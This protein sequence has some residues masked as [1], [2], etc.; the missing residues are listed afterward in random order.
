MRDF[1]FI[2]FFLGHDAGDLCRSLLSEYRLLEV[3]RASKL[4][5]VWQHGS[6][7]GCMLRLPAGDSRLISLIQSLEEHGVSVFRRHDREFS[8]KE[9][10]AAPW[11]ILRVATAGLLGG[12]DYDQPYDHSRACPICGAGAQ[13][14]PPL[15]AQI[16]KVGKK[17]ID[18]LVYENHLIASRPVV[19]SLLALALTGLV[20]EP[21][22]SPRKHPSQTHSWIRIHA[23][24]SLLDASSLG[25]RRE[26]PC[27]AC[28]RSGHYWSSDSPWVPSLRREPA[29]DFSLSWQYF[30]DW[31]Q[32]RS[33]NQVRAVGGAQEIIVSQRARRVLRSA[34]VRFLHW[35]PIEIVGSQTR[36]SRL[37]LEER[38][39]HAPE[40]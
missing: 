21:V 23:A 17:M 16:T 11:L 32:N 35:I 8:K 31:T 1:T 14:E 20:A 40:A 34:R 18:H 25:L 13:P 37:T 2:S 24:V 4:N 15:I 38:R 27:T 10:D 22:R 6:D 28:E 29:S 3:A 12:V 5:S 7:G 39:T 33:P 9:L 26:V 30:G 36:T 19:S